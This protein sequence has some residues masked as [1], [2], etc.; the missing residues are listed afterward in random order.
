MW[1]PQLQQLALRVVA[2]SCTLLRVATETQPSAA[3]PTR[4]QELVQETAAASIIFAAA[5]KLRHALSLPCK[6]LTSQL[7]SRLSL[8]SIIG[9][10]E[11][12]RSSEMPDSVA[13]MPIFI[14][15]SMLRVSARFLRISGCFVLAAG[16][17]LVQE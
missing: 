1:G 14:G 3:D 4:A 2:A 10:T 17:K 6:S 9:A 5:T 12:R 16:T 13:E 7:K 15:F 11:T 8:Q